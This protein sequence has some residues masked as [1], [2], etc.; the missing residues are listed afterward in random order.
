MAAEKAVHNV[1]Q[2]ADLHVDLPWEPEFPMLDL[3]AIFTSLSQLPPLWVPFD[4]APLIMPDLVPDLIDS[5]DSLI[6][7]GE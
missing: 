5:S 7:C 6:L 2:N 3:G 4:A 1:I